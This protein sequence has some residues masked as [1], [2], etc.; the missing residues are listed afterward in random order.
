MQAA[1]LS[2]LTEQQ[3]LDFLWTGEQSVSARALHTMKARFSTVHTE[4]PGSYHQVQVL[5]AKPCSARSFKA[6]EVSRN[7]PDFPG[8]QAKLMTV[9]CTGRISKT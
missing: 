9:N 6:L 8:R 4:R 1:P 3:M 2:V 5:H 7:Y